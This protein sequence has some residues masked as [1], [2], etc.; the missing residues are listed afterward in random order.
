MMMM[1]DGP[2]QTRPDQTT[3]SDVLLGTF[4]YFEVILGTLRYF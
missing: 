4:E 1:H 3:P 2:D